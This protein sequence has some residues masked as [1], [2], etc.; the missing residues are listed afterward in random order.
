MDG[1]N[2]K[3]SA[4]TGATEIAAESTRG[5]KSTNT[6]KSTKERIL[7]VAAR[8]FARHGY[9]GTSLRQITREAGVNVAAIHYH[10]GSKEG[11]YHAVVFGFFDRIRQ[12]R[13][14]MLAECERRPAD[15]PELLESIFRAMIAPHVRLVA[16]G[17][18]IEYLRLLSRFGGEPRD[19]TMR[20]YR[21]EIDP[22]R[23]KLI[24]ALRR[25]LPRLSDEALFR[26]FGFVANLMASAPFDT[27]YET[28]SGQSPVP[29]D[30]DDLIELLVTFAAAGFRAL[31]R[32]NP[33]GGKHQDPEPLQKSD[34]R[35]NPRMP[36]GRKK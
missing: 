8:N 21:E 14:T 36:E 22:V 9:A 13:L 19:I 34:I 17:D 12:R 23:Q 2:P 20:V 30:P 1:D 26:G 25:A 6:H 7:E 11:I 3:A 10:F 33:N 27:G 18:G 15:D 32:E 31:T 16:D 24:A 5:P 35:A 28:L 4:R 29:R